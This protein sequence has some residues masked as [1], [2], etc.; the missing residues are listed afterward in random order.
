M[1]PASHGYTTV[2]RFTPTRHIVGLDLGQSQDF[3]AIAVLAHRQHIVDCEMKG[4]TATR[5]HDVVHLSRFRLGTSYP[6]IVDAVGRM[7]KSLPASPLAP[8]L[9]TD[10][11]GVGRPVIDLLRKSGLKPIAVTITGGSEETSSGDFDHRIPKRNIV[12]T[13][14]VAL[15]SERLKIARGLPDTDNLINELA[16]F[17]MKVL[18]SGH[19]SFEA[20]RES[21]HDDLVLATGLATWFCERGYDGMRS[22]RM[23]YMSR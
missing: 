15:Q 10:A 21:I 5:L 19:E 14:Q 8:V 11:T 6:D 3:T 20:W 18:A 17:K 1:L 13:L 23:D 7:M 2:E 9:L 16:N 22:F 12:S 4:R